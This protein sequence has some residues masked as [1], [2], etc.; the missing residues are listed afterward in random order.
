[1][2]AYLSIIYVNLY[3][4]LKLVCSSEIPSIL[5]DISKGNWICNNDDQSKHLE[6]IEFEHRNV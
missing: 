3:S 4:S 2:I 5:S 6:F 1:M